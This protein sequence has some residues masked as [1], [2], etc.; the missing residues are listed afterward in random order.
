MTNPVFLVDPDAVATADVGDVVTVVGAEGRH[1]VS[2]R[3]L[4]VGEA[5]DLVDGSGRRVTG[6]VCATDRHGFQV[7]ADVIVADPPPALRITVVQ[8]L[9]KGDRGEAAVEM[10]TECGVDAIVPW[11]AARSVSRWTGDKEHRGPERWRAVAAA[12]TKQSRR[13]RL[14]VVSGLARSTDVADMLAQARLGLV[15]HEGAV[16]RLSR[17]DLPRGEGEIVV[18]VGPEGGIADDERAL[19]DAAGALTVRLGESVLRTS[20]AGVAA[21]AVLMAAS[22]RWD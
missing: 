11:A 20:T 15:L 19:F 17:L 22:G 3:R 18:V 1:G 8:A 12:A 21:A 2:V 4:R 7:R 14:P 16:A 10:L 9:A 13:S 5:V 6:P